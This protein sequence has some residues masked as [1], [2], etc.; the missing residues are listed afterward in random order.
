MFV[1]PNNASLKTTAP[2]LAFIYTLLRCWAI[3]NYQSSNA[4][5][6]WSNRSSTRYW[7]YGF[8]NLKLV[9]EHFTSPFIASFLRK[10]LLCWGKARIVSWIIR[11]AHFRMTISLIAFLI[12]IFILPFFIVQ[13]YLIFFLR[14]FEA[15][16]LIGISNF[17]QPQVLWRF[18]LEGFNI[19]RWS[20][21]V[22]AFFRLNRPNCAE[23]FIFSL[24]VS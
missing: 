23:C 20:Q 18:F 22:D 6:C 2:L 7:Q 9:K 21:F 24:L 4:G 15:L 16:F 11:L 3:L 14:I 1:C 17:Q 8:L 19:W 13:V 12:L 10:V 5:Y